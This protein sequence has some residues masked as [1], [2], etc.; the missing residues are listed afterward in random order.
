MVN[1]LDLNRENLVSQSK[2][3]KIEDIELTDLNLSWQEIMMAERIDF[4][5]NLENKIKLLKHR[6]WTTVGEIR[7][8]SKKI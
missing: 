3:K 1:I 8:G 6:W 4:T 7:K 5:C 2:N